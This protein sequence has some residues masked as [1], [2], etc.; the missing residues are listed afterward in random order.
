MGFK[1][2][3]Y[4]YNNQTSINNFISTNTYEVIYILY[5][6]RGLCICYCYVNDY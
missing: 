5:F 4:G 2:L 3:I 6:K 1:K